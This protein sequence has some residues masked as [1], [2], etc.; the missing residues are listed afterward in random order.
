MRAINKVLVAVTAVGLAATMAACSSSTSNPKPVGAFKTLSGQST[1]VVLDAGFLKAL[2]TLKLTPGLIGGAKLNGADL[3]FPITGGNATIYKKG[4]ITPYVQ[5]VINHDGS[6]LSLTA[7][8]TVVKLENFVVH[9]GNDSNLTGQVT[10][11]GKVLQDV[12]LFDLDGNTLKTPTISS[13]GVATLSGTTVYLNPTAAKTLDSVFGT[14]ALEA[15]K[16]K[17]G[18]AI[19]KA[20]GTV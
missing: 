6:G 7:G 4:D 20:T 17:V 2:T 18:T 1:T 15:A 13:A 11:G 14:K 10:A 5:G 8:S 12:R 16:V 19:I 9:P 3:S